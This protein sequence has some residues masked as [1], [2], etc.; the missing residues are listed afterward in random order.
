MEGAPDVTW[1]A[2]LRPPMED[3][4]LAGV[5]TAVVFV[6]PVILTLPLAWRRR[7]PLTVFGIQAF[8]T[9]LA[10]D[11]LSPEL[12]AFLAI[13]VGVYSVAAHCRSW[14][15]SL[16][17]VLTFTTATA[18]AFGEV[19]PPI[20]ESL[21]AFALAVPLWLAGNQIRLFRHRAEESSGRAQRAERER[22]SAALAA[23]A[24]ERARIARELHDVVTHNVSVMVVQA[25][26]AR[27]VIDT[28]PAFARDALTAIERVGQQA[29]TELREMLGVLA[30]QGETPRAPQSGL[31][32][33]PS[34]VA[35]VRSAGVP[36]DIGQTGTP[37]PL[38]PGVDVAAYRVVQE[39][40]TNVL[41]HAPGA[42]TTVRI[43]HRAAE[44]V[45]EVSNDPAPARVDAAPEGGR[46]LIGLAER[47][48][49]HHGELTYGPRLLGGYR[50]A[51]RFPLAPDSS[52][53]SSVEG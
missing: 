21:T 27:Q 6:P 11:D 36:V 13:T 26:A 30:D 9:F 24:H 34:L 5:L 44:L 47:L 28:E 23:I 40:L 35:E 33:V 12:T 8:A 15:A 22:D 53:R 29:M 32:Q 43:D 3:V 19:T 25:S 51:A 4:V 14:W 37:R 2:R 7:F 18:V 38:P 41:R 45:V 50:V 17:A 52:A 20:P 39:A 49:V 31:A 48:H 46:G 1:R 42:A 16:A 10:G